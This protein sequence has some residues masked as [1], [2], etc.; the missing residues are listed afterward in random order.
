MSCSDFS[1]KYQ[2]NSPNEA[3]RRFE[4]YLHLKLVP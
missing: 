3:S 2:D 1:Q 4:A